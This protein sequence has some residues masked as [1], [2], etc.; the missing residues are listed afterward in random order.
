MEA[1]DERQ[2]FKF[3]VPVSDTYW[4]DYGVPL[5]FLLTIFTVVAVLIAQNPTDGLLVGGAFVALSLGA[6]LA[7]LAVYNVVVAVLIV[8]QQ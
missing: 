5:G 6:V 3:R 8:L 1:G 7:G 4:H 2:P